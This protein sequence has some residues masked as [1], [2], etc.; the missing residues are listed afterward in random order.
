[1]KRIISVVLFVLL[2]C[3]LQA[4]TWTP[5]TSPT[6][7]PATVSL[8]SDNPQASLLK[9]SVPGFSS[10]VVATPAGDRQ[11]ITI[12]GSTRIL[13]K[14][15]PDLPKLT[16][17][18]I[19][20]DESSMGLVITQSA[21]VEYTNID[22]APSKGNFTRDINPADVPYEWGIDYSKDQFFPG[23]LA[24]LKDPF[25]LRD[26][27]GQTVVFYPYQY[28][29]VT[30]VLR[31]YTSMEVSVSPNGST[32]TNTF[33]RTKALAALDPEFAEIYHHQF[34]NFSTRHKYTPLSENGKMLIISHGSFIPA[35]QA[36]VNWKIT[37]GI[38]TEIVDVATIGS[39]AAAIKTFVANYYTTNGLTF[40]LLV[41]D[42]A[43]IPT[44]ATT[45][46]DSDPTYGFIVGSDHYQDIL[47]GRFSAETDV[48][49]NTQV[50][51]SVNY[52]KNP[53]TTAGKFDH[54]IGIASSQGPGDDNEY[55]Y[56][57]IN[58]INTDLLGFT[59]SSQAALYEGSQGGADVAGDPTAADLTTQVNRGAS[60]I[61]YCG[62]GSDNSFVTT[63]F[64]N[65]N[66]TAL[67]NTDIHPFIWSVACVNGN[68]TGGTCFAEGWLRQ[69]YNGQPAGAVATLMSTIN[70]SW[71]P[72]MEGQDEMVDILAGSIAGN[73]KRTF[74]GLS[75]NGIFKMNDTYSDFA[76]TD[77]WTVFGDPSL[78]VRTDDPATMTAS[79][80]PILPIGSTSL[81]V[82]CNT[83]GAFVCV[84]M[85]NTILGTAYVTG[86]SAAISFSP[87]TSID[88]L[89]VC[90]TAFNYVPYL[91]SVLVNNANGPWVAYT[92]NSVNDA[93]GNNNGK[94]DFSETIQ[95]DINLHNFGSQTAT[96]VSAS[97]STT[98]ANISITDNNQVF[99]DISASADAAQSA[100]YAFNV[101]NNIE[102]Q[103]SLP[104]TLSVQDNAGGSWPATFTLVANAP[105]LAIGAFGINDASGNNNGVLD[106]GETADI[107]I[108]TLNN[109]H[110]DAPNTTGVLTTTTP[111]WITINS[112]THSF[113]TLALAS[114]ANAAFNLSVAPGVPDT[115]VIELIYTVTS[116]AYSTNYHYL[117]TLGL[118]SED[119][120]SGDFSQFDW[121]SGG[122]VPWLITTSAPYEGV[123]CAVSGNIGDDQT[124]TLEV[125]LDVLINDSIS[126]WKKVSSEADYDFLSFYID[127]NLM[128]QWSGTLAWSKE[129]YAV[130]AGIHLFKWV[131]S[132][133]Y[134]I[135]SGSDCAWVDYILFPPTVSGY[136]NISEATSTKNFLRCYPNPANGI[137]NIDFYLLEN[138]Q[139]QLDLYDLAGRCVKNL[140]SDSKENN[141]LHSVLLNTSNLESG[142]YFVKLSTEHQTNTIKLIITK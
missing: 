61:N 51:R 4:Q 104:F 123:D 26:L 82:N 133:D 113:G 94:V 79:H 19:I 11:V 86:G 69:T 50:S 66:M 130:T 71:D 35:M 124:S 30:K 65:S 28:N 32:A 1:M 88:T 97:L 73:I 27:R 22:I 93:S 125:T 75:V 63:G 58:N 135:S 2:S 84:S 3:S 53:S 39:S 98:D 111:Q 25:I 127:G 110:A 14:G 12:Q 121:V 16:A 85:N 102:D 112:G 68:F 91:G 44:N 41:G 36:F 55:D 76:M 122:N 118:V 59:Y 103:H 29:P 17:S 131:F 46:G 119:W 142:I 107:S 95:L 52:E 129:D 64:S 80:S 74:G 57:H 106:E 128:D 72:P 77:T 45:N 81:T 54:C 5:A 38:P 34:L 99:G 83:D 132:K 43:Q 21:Y 15:A 90:A 49:V 62:H 120:E 140:H 13:R 67:T 8:L 31:V 117:L 89:T 24:E 18:L 100:A 116:G 137:V 139:V 10:S 56:T 20:P 115:A 108:T 42:A 126:F 48:H 23:P 96:A 109:G 105:K 70:Q 114:N 136:S 9:M 60:I 134:I 7:E 47:V 37:E 78:M 40:L 92:A 138:D 6:P 101:V 141:G 33:N 87:L